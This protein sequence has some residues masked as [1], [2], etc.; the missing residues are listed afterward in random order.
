MIFKKIK[1]KIK[2]VLVRGEEGGMNADQA[3]VPNVLLIHALPYL[4]PSLPFPY[5]PFNYCLQKER[6]LSV[7]VGKVCGPGDHC[8]WSVTWSCSLVIWR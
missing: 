2:S 5:L 8:G 4:F 7:V 1:I 3:K 6:K